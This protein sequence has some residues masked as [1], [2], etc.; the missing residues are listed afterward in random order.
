MAIRKKLFGTLPDGKAVYA[1]TMEN[2]SGIKVR[3]MD[4]GG[5][6]LMIKVPDRFGRKTDVV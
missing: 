6:V 5:T 2:A 4:L 1:Y 3:V